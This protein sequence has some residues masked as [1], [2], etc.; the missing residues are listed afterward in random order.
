VGKKNTGEIRGTMGEK[1]VFIQFMAAKGVV[2]KKCAG[3]AQQKRHALKIF[4]AAGVGELES[5][6]L[7]RAADE[8]TKPDLSPSDGREEKKRGVCGGFLISRPVCDERPRNP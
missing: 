8:K 5:G 4:A 3:A 2:Y 6:R 1:A 7:K